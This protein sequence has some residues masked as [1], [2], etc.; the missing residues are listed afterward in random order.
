MK[1]PICRKGKIHS[2]TTTVTLTREETTLVFK[3]VPAGIC[4]NCG[5]TYVDERVSK[6]LMGLAQEAA[7]SGIEV[8][9]RKYATTPL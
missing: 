6:D 4:D 9:I 8:D 2:G 1:C 3:E 7:S 5:E